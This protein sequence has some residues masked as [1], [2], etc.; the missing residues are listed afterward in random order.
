[1]SAVR[2]LWTALSASGLLPWVLL[3]AVA[4]IGIAG[5]AG[6][7]A[8]HNWASTA[9]AADKLESQVAAQAH[10]ARAVAQAQATSDKIW[11]IDLQLTT[12]LA[13]TRTRQRVIVE[14]VYRDVDAHPDL[15]GCLVPAA[16]QR[17]RDEQVR[18]SERAAEG[19]AVQR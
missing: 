16:T 14:E 15:A 7:W 2:T 9:C 4:A 8:G 13:V 10:Q 11:A 12:D 19:H 18:D 17:L 3:G 6:V 5:G 1:M